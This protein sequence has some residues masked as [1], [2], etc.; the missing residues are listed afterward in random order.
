MMRDH[1]IAVDWGS[2]HLRAWHICNNDIVN[3]LEIPAGVTRL[4]AMS[5][6]DIFH[7]HIAPW[8]GEGNV[9]VVMAGMIGSEAGWQAVPYEATPIALPSLAQRLCRVGEQIW[10]VPGLKVERDDACNVMRGEE[11]QLLGATVL[12]PSGCYVMPGTHCKWVQVEGN[13]VR[14]FDTIM[15]GELHHLLMNHSL[16]GASCPQ[17]KPDRAAFRQGLEKGLQSPSLLS[18][19]FEARA[20][21]VLN[22]LSRES[23]AEYLSGLLI[24]AEVAA[25]CRVWQPGA[26]TLV[27]SASLNARYRQ[28]FSLTGVDVRTCDGD[29]AFLQ[30]IRSIIHARQ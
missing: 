22:A 21:W 9:P 16:I 7:Q 13:Q 10:I 28:A 26:V 25:Q 6:A 11:T 8:R 17:Q 3:H 14:H 15:T 23:V 18:R 1:Y 27:G 20:A 30:G 2:T 4:G 19:L 24:G 12:M 29:E 5:A